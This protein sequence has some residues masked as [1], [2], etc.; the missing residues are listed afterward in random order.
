MAAV[1]S[2]ILSATE[3]APV[4]TPVPEAGIM[5]PYMPPCRGAAF[6]SGSSGLLSFLGPNNMSKEWLTWQKIDW[7]PKC[8]ITFL[9]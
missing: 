4:S 2:L 5:R 3:T 6:A 7:L 8:P 1:I 9:L